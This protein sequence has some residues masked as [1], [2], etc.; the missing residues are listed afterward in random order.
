VGLICLITNVDAAEHEHIVSSVSQPPC[1]PL[2]WQHV[3]SRLFFAAAVVAFGAADS[4]MCCGTVGAWARRETRRPCDHLPATVFGAMVADHTHPNPYLGMNL[5]WIPGVSYAIGTMFANQPMAA[6]S[7]F[8]G[9]WWYRTEFALPAKFAGQAIR[10]GFD[11]IN[12]RA[13]WWRA[14]T[15]TRGRGDCSSST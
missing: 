5:R 10:L 3:A 14:R 2:H 6:D 4:R 13:N 9:S 11:G 8:A 1:V 7:P 12:Y 15:G